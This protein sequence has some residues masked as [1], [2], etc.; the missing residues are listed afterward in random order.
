MHARVRNPREERLARLVRTFDEIQRAGGE[1]LVRR[2]HA[3]AR[4]RPGVFDVAIG[5]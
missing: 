3:L 5:R 2:L 4:H 1:V